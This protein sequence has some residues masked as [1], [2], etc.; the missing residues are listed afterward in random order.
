MYSLH[1]VSHCASKKKSERAFSFLMKPTSLTLYR[2]PIS[3]LTRLSVVGFLK[4]GN[5]DPEF[6][7]GGGEGKKKRELENMDDG[8]C[9]R[10]K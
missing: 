3:I 10:M 4:E 5:A 9:R 7:K 6:F 2:E 8:L 1:Q